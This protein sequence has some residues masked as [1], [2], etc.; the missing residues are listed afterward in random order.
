[1]KSVGVDKLAG[2]L[3][4]Q[5]AWACYDRLAEGSDAMIKWWAVYKSGWEMWGTWQGTSSCVSSGWL[6]WEWVL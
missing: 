5:P 2:K 6:E 1:L 4:V 3:R